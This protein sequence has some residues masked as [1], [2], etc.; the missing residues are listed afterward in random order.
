MAHHLN[1]SGKRCLFAFE[2]A[3]GFMVGDACYD[4]DGVRAAAV[5]AEMATQLY[6]AGSTLQSHL[7]FLYQKYGHFTSRNRYFFCYDPAK[8]ESIFQAIRNFNGTGTYPT[9]IGEIKVAR[10]RDLTTG[11]DSST[12]DNKTVL[13]PSSS[14]QMITFYFENG[15]VATL[16]GSGTEPKLKYYIEL[17]G[18][19][20]ADVERVIDHMAINV[21]ETCLRPKQN[22]LEPP[23]N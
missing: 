4:K 6:R 9:E 10:V 15:C 3:I 7:L 1:T 13:P 18:P 22:D 12:P 2:E 17:S 8:L 23:K 16:R 5:F 21:I 11:Y 20:P 14:T 19:V